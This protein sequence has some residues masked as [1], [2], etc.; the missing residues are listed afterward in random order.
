MNTPAPM[1]VMSMG[2]PCGIGPELICRIWQ[3]HQSLIGPWCVVGHPAAMARAAIAIGASHITIECVDTVAEAADLWQSRVSQREAQ[4]LIVVSIEPDTELPQWGQISPVAG[5]LSALSVEVA[6]KACLN[7]EAAALVTAPIHKQALSM[8]GW[9]VPGHT[10]LLQQLS[11]QHMGV[12]P[13]ALPV[14]MML[15]TSDLRTVLHSIHVSL[16]DALDAITPASLLE[17]LRITQDHLPSPKP[18][19]PLRVAVAGVNPHAGEGGLFGSEEALVLQP[20]IAEARSRGWDVSGP[21][22]P[23]TVFMRAR[24]GDF[25]VVIAMYHDQGLIPIKYLG[26]DEGVNVTLG[27]PFVRTSPDHG[28]AF[29]LA[30]RGLANPQSMLHAALW[31]RAAVESHKTIA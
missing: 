30:G 5:R 22:A 18:E 4:A 12:Q 26:L 14:R 15:A 13:D 21:H 11:V 29:D 28:T 3:E 17:T 27:L 24:S 9:K 2:D 20:T 16:R 25:D 6:A 19:R 23:D 1:L 10:E 31:A 7:A 8:A